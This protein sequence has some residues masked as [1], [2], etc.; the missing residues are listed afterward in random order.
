MATIPQTPEVQRSWWRRIAETRMALTY[1][2][3]ALIVLAIIT[4]YPLGY[5]VWMSFT[6]YGL[7]NLRATAPAPDYVGFDNYINILKNDI[8]I[9]NFDFWRLLAF[10]LFW[11]VS[12]VIIHVVLGV[13]IAVLLNTE[14]LW[15]KRI[16]RA[17]YV[18]PVVIP[19]LIIATVWKN[20]FDQQAGPINQVL[21]AVGGVFGLPASTFAIPWLEQYAKDP[22]PWLG[23]LPLSYF[24]MLIANSWLGWPL[25][26][27]VATGALQ[28]I[29]K[30]LYEAATIDG[31]SGVQQF[32]KITVP[33]LRPA[34]VP[35][36]ILGFIT[37]FNLFYLSYFLSG[38][39]P[40]GRTEL[41]V[42]QAYRL[43]NEQ[44]LYGVAAAF[45]IFEF[46]ILLV[47]SLLVNRTA[48]ATASYDT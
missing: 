33:L 40:F 46:F 23:L 21:K 13:L 42:T 47:L 18:L 38:G 5:Q 25:N 1:T 45:A 32:F 37:T 3:P 48:K 4:A 20:M 22:I 9:P 29:P 17:I 30:E 16:Y 39:G 24:A 34:M 28:S 8:S 26:A 14:G 43:V 2:L 12:N 7:K 27:V 36:A 41:L 15:F 19:G 6:D 10:N 31:A 44:K 35:F 11:A